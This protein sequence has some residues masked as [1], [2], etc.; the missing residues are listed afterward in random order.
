MEIRLDHHDFATIG[1]ERCYS[2][3]HRCKWP[4]SALHLADDELHGL[5]YLRGIAAA[6]LDGNSLEVD[7]LKMEERAQVETDAVKEGIASV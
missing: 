1:G 3:S 2:A 4:M 6:K 5:A 7:S